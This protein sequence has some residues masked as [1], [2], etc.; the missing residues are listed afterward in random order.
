MVLQRPT[1]L[2]VAGC[3]ARTCSQSLNTRPVLTLPNTPLGSCPRA[4]QQ[5]ARHRLLGHCRYSI[6]SRLERLVPHPISPGRAQRLVV[7]TACY[8]TALAH[9]VPWPLLCLSPAA[10]EMAQSRRSRRSRSPSTRERGQCRALRRTGHDELLRGTHQL[11]AESR[12]SAV[13][14]S[15][16]Y[17]V[18]FDTG[19]IIMRTEYRLSC[20]RIAPVHFR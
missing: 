6:I 1:C 19:Y 3:R 14:T 15:V 18:Y 2:S 20:A 16:R 11:G 12:T 10:A 13:R 4:S 9:A 8:L 17:S 5:F 7:L